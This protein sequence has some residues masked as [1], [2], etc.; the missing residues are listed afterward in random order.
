MIHVCDRTYTKYLYRGKN[1]RNARI[2][3]Q[4]APKGYLL[5]IFENTKMVY[6]EVKK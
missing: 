5:E 6:K 2:M 4:K 3:F 1:E